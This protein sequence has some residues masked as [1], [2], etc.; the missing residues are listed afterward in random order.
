MHI[1]GCL[2]AP[3]SSL[4]GSLSWCHP[5]FHGVSQVSFSLDFSLDLLFLCLILFCFVFFCFE[6]SV[7]SLSTQLGPPC[8]IW[9]FS[10]FLFA[11]LVG[12]RISLNCLL[13]FYNFVS[14]AIQEDLYSF[15]KISL[16]DLHVKDDLFLITLPNSSLLLK[17]FKHLRAVCIFYDLKQ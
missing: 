15:Q 11:W 12:F 2:L 4:T 14:L 16:K 17:I 8:P 10:R 5:R 6:L 13:I 1:P 3:H 9:V 7:S